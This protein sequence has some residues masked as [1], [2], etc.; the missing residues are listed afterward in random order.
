MRFDPEQVTHLRMARD[1]SLGSLSESAI[2][3]LGAQISD[4]ALPFETLPH[5]HHLRSGSSD[6][7]PANA[8]SESAVDAARRV[9]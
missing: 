8:D 7:P 2:E 3:Q 6:L 1:N 4:C 5:F 9:G